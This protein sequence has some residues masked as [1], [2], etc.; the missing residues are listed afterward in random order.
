MRNN[1]SDEVIVEIQ[2][3]VIDLNTIFIEIEIEI[4]GYIFDIKNKDNGTLYFF[5]DLCRQNVCDEFIEVNHFTFINLNTIV[6]RKRFMAYNY[7]KK[8]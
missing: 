7:D 1:T 2:F 5:N 3:T 6:M 4:Y 8:Q